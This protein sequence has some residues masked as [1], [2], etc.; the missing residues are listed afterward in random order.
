[1]IKY[2]NG[3]NKNH[4]TLSSDDLKV[5]KWYVDEIFLVLPDFKSRTE[6]IMTLGQVAMHLVSS[7]NKLNT[8]RITEAELFDVYDPSV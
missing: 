5:I 6:A 3:G 1:M 4:L 2:L 7:K 8:R